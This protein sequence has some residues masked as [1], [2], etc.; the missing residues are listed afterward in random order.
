KG[1]HTLLNS[2]FRT[3]PPTALLLDEPVLFIA[4]RDHL[5]RKGI[6]APKSVSLV[7]CDADSSF[8]WCLPQVTHIRW[9]SRLIVQRVVRWADQIGRGKNDR[10]QS[11]SKAHLVVGGTIGPAPG[12]SFRRPQSTNP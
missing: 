5:A 8:D 6:V 4:A 11:A 10:R 2:L 7:C 12:S 9:D 1:L 3:T